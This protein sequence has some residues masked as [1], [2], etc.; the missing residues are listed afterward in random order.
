MIK[1]Y[2]LFSLCL[3]S[4]VAF[5]KVERQRFIKG[6]ILV[7][8]KETMSASSQ[9][10]S[11]EREGGKRLARLTKK[12]WNR[13][14][15][16]TEANLSATIEEYK[17]DPNVE[18]AQPNYIYHKLS[19]TPNDV[20]YGQQ[21]GLKNTAQTITSNVTGI[22]QPR[23]E[24]NPG[25]AGKDMGLEYAWDKITNCSSVI[26]AVVDSGINYDQTDLAANMWDGGVTYPKHGY[27]FMDST[28]DPKDNNGHGTHVAG[29][30]GA[31]GNNSLGTT[32]VCWGVKLM[33]VKVLDAAGSGTSATV[34]SGINFAVD[35]GAKVINMSI[36]GSVFDPA[37]NTAITYAQ[38]HGV[39]VVTA[40]GNESS[41][42]ESV[43][44]PT[45]PCNFT[46]SNIVCVAALTQNY[47]LASFS[48]YGATSVDV[49]APGSNI[50]ST[51]AGTSTKLT[52]TLTS[53]WNFA[54]N[55]G[56]AWGYK[57]LN[58]IINGATVT[59]SCLVNPTT[60]NH[61]T[62]MYANNLN[63]TAWSSFNLGA[64]NAAILNFD[65]LYDL[66]SNDYFSVY[67]QAGTQDPGPAGTL[68]DYYTGTSNG[69]TESVSVNISSFTG[70]TSSLGFNLETDAT[71]V[72][73]GVALMDFNIETLTYANANFNV[74][75]G[76]SMA[77]P[78]VSGLAAMLFALNP[79]YT[80]N[81]V[82]TSIKNGGVTTASLS[83]KT[84]TGKAVSAIGSVN[85]I[86][87]PSGG[88]A[89]KLP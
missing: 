23:V 77:T 30:I 45:Y 13:V 57:N 6:E 37:Y 4:N 17:R 83:G 46:Q 38:T 15:L 25:V 44:T 31:V 64:Y 59:K 60:F 20:S 54:T 73:T 19:T 43:S 86:I 52:N 56:A 87:K 61:T 5:S 16:P 48:N 50:L 33:A 47:S 3:I 42:N 66:N 82:A 65:V 55:A 28:N 40:A 67:A 7:K 1:I 71:G 32:G 9:L 62:A 11:I 34:I 36:G 75:S 88:A 10:I 69:A 68:L 81:D 41:N 89:V 26:V 74:I 76:T 39:L 79:N 35:N 84:S 58:F 22:D 18:Y 85:Y 63:A 21:W 49:G 27:N 80:Y 53:G 78:H 29:T 8:Y 12:G 14:K 2:L 70:G 51:W 72:S 24:N